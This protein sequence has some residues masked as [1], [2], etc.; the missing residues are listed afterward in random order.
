[1][2]KKFQAILYCWEPI[3]LISSK[4]RQWFNIMIN[5]FYWFGIK[6]VFN[7]KM[8]LM[9][10]HLSWY[11]DLNHWVS[12]ITRYPNIVS[13]DQWRIHGAAKHLRWGFLRKCLTAFSRELFSIWF[14]IYLCPF[15]NE[16]KLF[17][18]KV[19]G[20]RHNRYWMLCER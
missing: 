6:Y 17:L 7:L 9:E 19:L 16:R 8:R 13:F 20:Q 15:C 1:M 5:W 12:D 3:P 14:W 10:I 18:S 2:R 11:Q 4:K